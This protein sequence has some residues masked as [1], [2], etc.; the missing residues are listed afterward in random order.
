MENAQEAL[1]G[2]AQKFQQFLDENKIKAFASEVAG[3]ELQSVV[4]RSR[5]E[6]A[7]QELPTAVVIDSSIYTMVR[8]QIIGGMIKADN[9]AGVLDHINRL[10]GQ[11][12]VF[13]YFVTDGG[14][15]CLDSCLPFTEENFDGEMI[16]TVINVILQHLTEEYPAL[17]RSVWAAKD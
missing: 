17:M 15:L 13:K 10:N 7:G 3:G 12:K 11:Y 5:M 4:F 6:V 16:R 9:R 2:K 1:Q 8:V 14:D